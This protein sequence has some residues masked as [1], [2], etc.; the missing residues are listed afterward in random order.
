MCTAC[1]TVTPVRSAALIRSATVN[2]VSKYVRSVAAPHGDSVAFPGAPVTSATTIAAIA[3]TENSNVAMRARCDMARHRSA[4][5]GSPQSAL[6]RRKVRNRDVT[7]SGRRSMVAANDR[8]APDRSRWPRERDGARAER[9]AGSRARRI[10]GPAPDQEAEVRARLYA[11][12][13]PT[14]RTVERIEH[15]ERIADRPAA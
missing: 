6:N 8:G 7:P 12:P 13:P 5:D 3:A 15:V 14:E 1:L 4:A 9:T 2:A 10:V 11:K